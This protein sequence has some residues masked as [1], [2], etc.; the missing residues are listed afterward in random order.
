MS[1]SVASPTSRLG[2]GLVA[3][4]LLSSSRLADAT[5][6]GTGGTCYFGPPIGT[7]PSN[8]KCTSPTFALPCNI[9]YCCD[10]FSVS[11]LSEGIE[12]HA[13]Y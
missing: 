4:L 2:A 9:Q 11:L 13:F 7:L 12:F 6:C 1:P 3:V 10:A 5:S 8:Q